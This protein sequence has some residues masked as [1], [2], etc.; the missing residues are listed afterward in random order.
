MERQMTPGR[1]PPAD[2]LHK[3]R[4]VR[5]APSSCGKARMN[6]ESHAP[7]PGRRLRK[8]GR[9]P[10]MVTSSYTPGETGQ[11]AIAAQLTPGAT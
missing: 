2:C 5:M 3:E 4:N 9:S 11:S 1:N 7:S 10:Q 6:S 8:I